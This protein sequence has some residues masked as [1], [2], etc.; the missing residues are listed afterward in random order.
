MGKAF[1]LIEIDLAKCLTLSVMKAKWN[2][3]LSNDQ[4]GTELHLKTLYF[5]S[6]I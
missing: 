2:C 5:I 3:Q 6:I 4:N 1:K